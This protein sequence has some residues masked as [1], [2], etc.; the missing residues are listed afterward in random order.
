M[1]FMDVMMP[2]MDGHEAVERI[3]D[4]ETTRFVPIIFLTARTDESV[5]SHCIEVGGDDFRPNL[6]VTLCSKAKYCPW[7]GS[8][9]CMKNSNLYAQMKKDEEMAEGCLGAVIA[10]NV[11]M[12]H[13]R[14]LLQPGRSS[15]A[16]FC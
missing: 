9:A 2:V 6:S 5:L 12:N 1:V 7:S 15:A 13:V 14:T 4:I 16:M 3:R 11:A 10:G 8:A